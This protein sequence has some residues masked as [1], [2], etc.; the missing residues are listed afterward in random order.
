MAPHSAEFPDIDFSQV[1]EKHYF[2]D[3][4]YN[5]EET[6]LLVKARSHGAKTK[7][8]RPDINRKFRKQEIQQPADTN[9]TEC[10]PQSEQKQEIELNMLQQ[11]AEPESK[12]Q[13]NSF[14]IKGLQGHDKP[15]INSCDKGYGTPGNTRNNVCSTHGH[16]LQEKQYSCFKQT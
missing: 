6:E 8:E 5:P 7:E 10:N 9:Q 3:L 1:T 14:H 4:I 16:S 13:M 12:Q 11:F 2:F 15:L